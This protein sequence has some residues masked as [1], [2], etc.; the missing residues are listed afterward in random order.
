MNDDRLPRASYK[1]LF[2]LCEHG[3]VNWVTQ[4][5]NIL[6]RYGFGIVY[7]NQQVGDPRLFIAK[8]KERI[9]DCYKQE[10]SD[11]VS[12]TSKLENYYMFK[13]NFV[14]EKY[15]DTVNI[16]KYRTAL[17]KFRCS[18]HKLSVEVGRHEKLPRDQRI[19]QYCNRKI[20][21]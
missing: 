4:I 5:K 2:N 3:R 7:I 8:F 1:M 18:N 15:L 10:W 21:F 19:C 14:F 6:F 20:C 11:N 13:N 17:C 12:H 9:I 16:R